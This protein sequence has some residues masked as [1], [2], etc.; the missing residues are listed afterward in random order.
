[1]T[2]TLPLE[3]AQV[4]RAVAAS[5]EDVDANRTPA[6]AHVPALAEAGLLDVG[7]DDLLAGDASDVRPAAEVIAALAEECM[8]TA[9]GL[10]AHRMATDY[11]A[12]G[13]RGPRSETLLADLRAGR[14]V[15][16][17]AMAAG[18]KA[19]AGVGE[20]ATTATR[21][22]GG[23]VLE[24]FIPWASNLVDDA[25]L[26]LPSRTDD[27]GT[28]VAWVPVAAQGVGV[29]HL[30]GLLALDGTASGSV[31]LD[32]VRIDDD[33]VLSRDLTGFARA[34][35]PTFLVLQTAF[36]AGLVR[37]SLREA[38]AALDRG[39]NTVFGGEVAALRSDVDEFLSTWSRLAADTGSAGVRELLQ[40]RLDASHLAGRATRLEATL[41]G[42]RGYQTSTGASRRFREAAFLPV[43]SPSEGQ[44]RWE[45]SQLS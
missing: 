16:V 41:A 37:R 18:L 26:V 25:V 6:T 7:V 32:G 31:R 38:E 23:W 9:F 43:Q 4:L 40:L 29:R 44:L 15:G 39:D 1:M 5:A 19:L 8:P 21:T 34:F 30:S 42:G 22:D 10:W 28:L 33:Q 27:G 13:T 24:G 20:L 2:A 35:R 12:R 45:L 17:T 36:C 14:A 3:T 11:V